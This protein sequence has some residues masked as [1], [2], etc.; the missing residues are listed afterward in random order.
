MTSRRKFLQL[1][2]TT[3]AGSVTLVALT[4]GKGCRSREEGS[5]QGT[6]VTVSGSM[7]PKELKVA[8]P[9]EHVLVDFIGADQVSRDRYDR[10]EAYQVILPHLRALHRLGCDSFV[11]CTP[12]YLGRDPLLL[13]RLARASGLHILTNTGY[14]GAANDQYVPAHAYRESPDE[15][16]ARWVREW[17]EGIEDTGIFPGFMKI[18]VDAGPLSGIDRKLVIAAARTH[19][20]TGLTIACHTGNGEAA[21]EEMEVLKQEGVR[22][23]AL[24]W[25]HAQNAPDP[26]LHVHA[27]EQGVWVEFD[28]L[29]PDRI[30]AYLRRVQYM[31]E[32]GFLGNVLLSHDAGWYS[33]GEPE[34]G[35]YR[36]HDTLFTTFIPA[37]NEAGFTNEEI[38]HM[39]VENPRRAFTVGIQA[40]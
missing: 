17:E 5:R 34:G 2:G 32:A 21:L 31:K 3:L 18:G 25:V 26:D 28:G 10:N 22:G 37:L 11:E 13:E 4:T 9:H 14:Y 38:Q 16:S 15:L 1:A 24:I 39:T 6:I 30:D 33:V 23:S 29:R 35:E 27:A 36:P 12:A 20:K 8:L 7:D 40:A 19:L